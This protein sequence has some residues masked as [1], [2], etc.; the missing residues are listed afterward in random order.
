MTETEDLTREEA[1]QIIMNV[2]GAG[3]P[4]AH[5]YQFFTAGIE[6]Y[7]STLEE[8]YL[9]HYIK[10]GGSSFKLITGTYG[11]GKTHFLYTLQ[12]RAWEHGY[13]TSYIELSPVSTPFHRLEEV[14]RAVASHLALPQSELTGIEGLLRAWHQS[15]AEE[16]SG[17]SDDK[18]EKA[19]QD[20][21]LTTG[22]YEI[23][24]FQN[25]VREA[26][27]ALHKGDMG[28][29]GL[30]LQWLKGEN[31]PL[32]E[33][34][35]FG[36]FSKLEKSTAFRMMR[37]L[38]EWIEDTGYPG[39]IVLMDEAEQT[40]SISTRQKEAMLSNLRELVDACSSGAVRGAMFFYAVPDESFLEGRTAIYE[41]LT[42]R[43][44]TVFEGEMN[45]S[46]VR[47]DLE[48]AGPEPL[49]MLHEIGDK[50][51]AIFE[52]AYEISF[53]KK[54]LERVI[55][56]VAEQAYEEKY[57]EIGYKRTFVQKVVRAF[58]EL[59]GQA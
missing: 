40:P 48:T 51:A 19:L 27:M 3:Q 7:I 59:K 49:E 1:R 47:I 36:I 2:G 14:Y 35:K 26:F 25:A 58:H 23:T 57:G 29:I 34:R 43:L 55:T 42:Q 30:L 31:P 33:L 18:L 13:V 11:G 6:P 4:P 5:G 9:R 50:L 45:P 10:N 52:T 56:G 16:F 46:G 8:E 54:Q 24:G 28:S 22:P 39:L 44:S 41:A 32:S 21:L 37:C 12:G 38:I 20:Y 17:L 53:D 15:K